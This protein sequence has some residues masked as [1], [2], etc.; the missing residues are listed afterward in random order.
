M[1]LREKRLSYGQE[2]ADDQMKLKYI[3]IIMLTGIIIG[4]V[5]LT[6]LLTGNNETGQAIENTE[7]APPVQTRGDKTMKITIGA[8][9]LDV[10]LESNSSS[11]ALLE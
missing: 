7:P 3:I 9:V 4:G 1:I 8:V 11:A 10:D 2:I 6:I 5:V